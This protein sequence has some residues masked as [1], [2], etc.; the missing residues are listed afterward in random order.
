VV[1]N[2]S[3]ELKKALGI[4]AHSPLPAPA[5][6]FSELGLHRSNRLALMGLGL[7]D[8]TADENRRISVHPLV[9]KHLSRRSK[10]DFDTYEKMAEHFAERANG[11][12]G[13]SRLANN[14]WA[15]LLYTR[16]RKHRSVRNTG[17]P[18]AD[19]AMEAVRGLMRSTRK[20]LA[21]QR[22]NELVK[23][24][25]W[26][27]EARLLQ[28]EVQQSL[29]ADHNRIRDAYKE[30]SALC[31]TPELFHH[32][33]SWEDIRKGGKSSA[34]KTL[35]RAVASFPSNAR[36]KRR[37][38]GLSHEMGQ[39]KG[40]EALLREALKAE[41]EMPDT[42]VQLAQV[43]YEIQP[44]PWKESESLLRM[45]VE[46]D[47]ENRP[48][49]AR[50]GALLRR[51]GMAE[52]KKRTALWTEALGLLTAASG[53]ESR[54]TRAFTELGKLLLD[55]A[56]VGEEVDLGQAEDCF[57]RANKLLGGQDPAALVGL[58]RVF[59]RTERVEEGAKALEKALKKHATH[60]TMAALGELY[61][62]QG[63]IFRA[64][65]EFREAWQQSPEGAPEK[66]LYKLEL[67][68]L[69]G[70]ISSG[71][72]VAIEK[73]AEGKDFVE[74]TLLT[75]GGSGPRRDAGKT[76]VRR[77]SEKKAPKK[78][79]AAKAPKK[80]AAAKAPKKAAAAKAPKKAA[81]AKAPKKAA[82]AKAPKKAAA[83]K[84]PKKAAA[85]KDPKKAPP[86]E[87]P[88]KEAPTADA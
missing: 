19:H 28:I 53:K 80:A 77:K 38:A 30:T 73:E 42:Y 45:A 22:A 32:Q 39:H 18:M 16:A 57:T 48:A 74:P 84:A 72:A 27:T 11:S 7:L 34:A 56:Q 15:N 17:Y 35:A 20:D 54:D 12:E 33:A 31:A 36:L 65:K 21:T 1:E 71:A 55:R 63:K 25:A 43:L 59:L 23:R 4:I 60:E 52:E 58:A 70:L 75:T 29:K 79:A 66:H 83:A 82:A 14:F 6:V 40:A 10:S 2:L 78:A 9:A 49:M 3:P 81:A 85:A 68:R 44:L 76:V 5:T 69:E 88:T 41:P 87:A 26:N 61:A 62:F 67:T 37:L 46:L 86:E 47:G 8:V 51:R 64:E 50:L 24:N 13:D